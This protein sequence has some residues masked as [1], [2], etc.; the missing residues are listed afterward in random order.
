LVKPGTHPLGVPPLQSLSPRDF[1]H[2]AI[3]LVFRRA[4]ALGSPGNGRRH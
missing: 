4:A 1:D 2:L 3:Q